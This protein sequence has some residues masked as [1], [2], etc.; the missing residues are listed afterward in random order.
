M[1]I[2]DDKNLVDQSL[3]LKGVYHADN[4]SVCGPKRVFVDGVEIKNVIFIDINNR[5]IIK[6]K[7]NLD[8]SLTT[9]G[10]DLVYELIFGKVE[11]L[12]VMEKQTD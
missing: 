5:C 3:N 7:T 8:G 12:D 6:N 11:V 2:L 4:L 1:I 10:C 9:I